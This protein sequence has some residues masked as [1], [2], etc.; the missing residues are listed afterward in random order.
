[1]G[2]AVAGSREPAWGYTK[3][4]PLSAWVVKAWFAIF[5][6]A[7]WAYYLLAMTLAGVALWI[8][9]KVSARWLDG[10]KRAAGLALLTLVPFYNFHALKFNANTVLIPLWAATTLF[11]LRSFEERDRLSAAAPPTWRRRSS[12]PPPRRCPMRP[13]SATRSGRRTRTG[14]SPCSRLRLRSALPSG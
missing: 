13:R 12:W 8:A 5:P 14:G 7:D 4:P 1:M 3:H 2:E 11:F 6:L 9:W 10:E